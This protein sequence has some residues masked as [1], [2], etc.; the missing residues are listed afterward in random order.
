MHL[1]EVHSW[2]KE[3]TD[4]YKYMDWRVVALNGMFFEDLQGYKDV[5][6][7]I[8]PGDEVTNTNF[9]FC[10]LNKKLKYKSEACKVLLKF[11]AINLEN[12]FFEGFQN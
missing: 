4:L 8:T 1:A 6:T 3:N 12:I 10:F 7:Q 11:E 9:K 5:V 2:A